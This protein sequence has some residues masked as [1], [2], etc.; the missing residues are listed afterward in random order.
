MF[1]F[2][3]TIL[4]EGIELRGSLKKIYNISWYKSN[5]ILTL[6][7]I[8]YPFVLKNL[9]FYNL[10]F[11]IYLLKGMNLS[12][13]KIKKNIELNINQLILINSYKGM[14]HKLNLPVRG[15]RTRTNA[16]TQRSKRQKL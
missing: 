9:N 11:L 10:N 4:L 12:E 1:L 3:D 15:Q 6:M 16:G 13:T 8:S 5:I 2:R 14:R 7:G